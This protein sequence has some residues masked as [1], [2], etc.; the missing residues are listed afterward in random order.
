MRSEEEIRKLLEAWEKDP[1]FDTRFYP[2]TRGGVAQV[3]IDI[4]RW[5]L[6]EE[7]R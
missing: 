2:F 1:V 6:E 4:L 7:R 5:I 3:I